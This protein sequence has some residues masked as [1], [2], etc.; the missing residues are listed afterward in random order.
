MPQS[1]CGNKDIGVADRCSLVEQSGVKVGGDAGARGIEGEYLQGGDE[2][3]GFATFALAMFGRCPFGALEELE[4]GDDRYKAVFREA[5]GQPINDL[6]RT[7]QDIDAD[8]GIE[9]SLHSVFST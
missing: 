3:R 1:G 6:F 5:C 4:L 9:N 7:T 8:V 2:A